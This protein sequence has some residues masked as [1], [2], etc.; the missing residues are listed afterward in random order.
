MK[1]FTLISFIAIVTGSIS[2]AQ[3]FK[4]LDKSPADIAYLP[5]N[6][7]H[8]RKAG[9][10]AIIK[11]IYGRPQKNGREVF[12][13]LVKYDEVWRT[14]ANEATEVKVYK[15]V[16]IAGKKLRAG[17]YSLYTIPGKDKW[18]II[19]N[20]EIDYWGAYN[21]NPDNDV[22]R[23]EAEVKTS[24]EE[25]E[26]FSIRFLDGKMLLGWDKTI[27]EVAVSN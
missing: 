11:I 16:M 13:N 3:S 22:L 20:S 27:A 6:F 14:G 21:Y 1:I 4:G 5:D 18:T 9:E 19:F 23:V 17:S 24:D 10:E 2:V 26:A 12:G 25:I 15:D 7:A 8:D